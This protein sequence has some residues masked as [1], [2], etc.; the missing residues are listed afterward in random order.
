MQS[1]LPQELVPIG[2]STLLAIISIS[3]AIF[4]AIGQT[5]FNERLKI[6]LATTIS[7]EAVNQIINSGV[8][9]LRSLVSA[10]DLP[11]VIKEYSRAVTQ[12]WVSTLT[13]CLHRMTQF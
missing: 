10:S 1:S 9:S 4:M 6:N 3:C 13:P 7:Q 5:V 12:V 2:S 11:A 8:T